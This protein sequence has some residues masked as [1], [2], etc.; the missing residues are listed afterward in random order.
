MYETLVY[1]ILN[2]G[3]DFYGKITCTEIICCVI[4]MTIS[5]CCVVTDSDLFSFQTK[6][7]NA[8][9]VSHYYRHIECVQPGIFNRMNE[10]Y[11]KTEDL[12]L[13]MQFFAFL[14]S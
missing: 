3:F 12:P 13:T 1:I 8:N 5:C 4:T 11:R 2:R 6:H 9:S 7:Q 10:Y 14:K